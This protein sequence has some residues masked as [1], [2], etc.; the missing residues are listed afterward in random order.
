MQL[1]ARICVDS[2]PSCCEWDNDCTVDDWLVMIAGAKCSKPHPPMCSSQEHLARLCSVEIK[3]AQL[4]VEREVS[5]LATLV[6]HR[7][8]EGGS[9]NRTKPLKTRI[10]K[11]R[12]KVL[13]FIQVWRLWNETAGIHMPEITEKD[14]FGNQLPWYVGPSGTGGSSHTLDYVKLKLHKLQNERKRCEEELM[15]LPS[16]AVRVLLYFG[17]QIALL[18]S[19]FMESGVSLQLPL[20]GRVVLM[21]ELLRKVQRLQ[22]DAYQVFLKIGLVLHD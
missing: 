21:Y 15:Y 17:R 19:W 12:I 2:M 10:R 16:D 11:T 22:A 9:G 3:V 6:A 13:W 14:A 7:V 5:V 1:C 20:S 8:Q 4:T 18:Q